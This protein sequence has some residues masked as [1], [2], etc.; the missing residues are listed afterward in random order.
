MG[1]MIKSKSLGEED[2][3]SAVVNRDSSFEGVFYFAVRTTGI[4]CRPTCHARKPKRENVAFYESTRDALNDG[5]RPC[6]L[7]Q[8]M[9]PLG[10]SPDWLK[11]LMNEIQENPG[12]RISDSELRQ[13]EIDPARL[14]RW[15]KKNHGMTFQTYLR[16]M[17][18][19]RAF[20]QIRHSGKVT[21]TAYDSGFESLSGFGDAFKNATGFAPSESADRRIVYVTR[22]QSPLGPLFAGAVDEGVCLLEFTDRRMLE[23]QI[24]RLKKRLGA[25][26]IPGNHPHFDE[27]N[28]QISA[29]FKGELQEFS[30]PLVLP[31]TEFQK[32]VWDELRSIPYGATRS[33]QD[34]AN[35]IGKPK[36]IRAVATANGDNRIAIIIPCH[37]VI[38]KD[39]ALVGY[40]GGI[41]RK[42]YLLDLERKNTVR[43][44]PVVRG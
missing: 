25:K 1:F 18:I 8:P 33:Y 44:K 16:L 40:G 42:Q 24:S 36:A 5:Y 23:T 43:P 21:D 31:G 28:K 11:P 37:R 17:R 15:F 38:G 7:C 20:G 4:F 35:A 19:S 29:Y 3:Y 34:Q 32:Q 14:R 9:Q 41:W 6:K 12:G 39:G 27:L 10:E 13:R 2:L 30:I 22:I 26:L